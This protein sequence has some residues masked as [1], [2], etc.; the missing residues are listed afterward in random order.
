M[1]TPIHLWII[2]ALS[3]AW[4][5]MGAMDYVMTVTRNPDYLA[6]FTPER[7]AFLEAFPTWAVASWALAIWLAVAGSV[8]LLLRSRWAAPA[9]FLG[10]V[11]MMV[12]SVHNLVLA[13]PPAAQTMGAFEIAFTLAIFL[14][15]VALWL[16]AR[17]MARRGVIT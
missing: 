13:D 8:L 2:G 17:A 7:L 10:L 6:Q 5:A 14:I 12:T 4:N 3:L 11:F 9:F 1:K 16:Y 15:A